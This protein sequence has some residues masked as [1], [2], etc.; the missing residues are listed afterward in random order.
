MTPLMKMMGPLIFQPVFAIDGVRYFPL[1]K[2]GDNS[3]FALLVTIYGRLNG[4][5][6]LAPY[7][8]LCVKK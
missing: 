4:C 6:F 8:L 5:N 3:I 1:T 2:K 7:S